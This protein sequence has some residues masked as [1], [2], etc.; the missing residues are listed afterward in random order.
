MTGN[1]Y[2]RSPD[3]QAQRWSREDGFVVVDGQKVTLKRQRL[4]KDGGEVRLGTY[5]LF[6]RQRRRNFDGN[7]VA[8]LNG[9]PG[10]P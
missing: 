6:P 2:Q 5:E 4:R 1:R 3:R 10:D 9:V 7:R 8:N